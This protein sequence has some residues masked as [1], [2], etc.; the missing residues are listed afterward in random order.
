MKKNSWLLITTLFLLGVLACKASESSIQTAIAQTQ[1]AQP[2]LTQT[3]TPRPTPTPTAA[4]LYAE[5]FSDP[6]SG[7]ETKINQN[8]PDSRFGYLEG[9][10]H[11]SRLAGQD[12][13]SWAYAHQD[14]DDAVLSVDTRHVSGESVG[15]SA[16]V[17]WRVAPDFSS[18]YTLYIT[19]ASQF[20][21]NKFNNKVNTPV[22]EWKTSSAILRGQKVNHIDIYFVDD[23][24][25]IYIN[26][27]R[28]AIFNDSSSLHGDIWLGAAGTKTSGVEI[29][30]DNLTVHSA[31]EA[32]LDTNKP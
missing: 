8:D 31:D 28:I 16:A 27:V 18:Y 25:I 2:T 20:Y 1:T 14:F 12:L 29:A 17:S 11:I 22:H 13:V 26:N 5:D 7:W 23:V 9:E 19:G 21:V 30:F 3:P 32:P 10:Y 4:L 15:T 6:L 24:S